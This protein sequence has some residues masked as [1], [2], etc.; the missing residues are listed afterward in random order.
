MKNGTPF[1]RKKAATV[2]IEATVGSSRKMALIT[3]VGHVS[4]GPTINIKI[5]RRFMTER[6]WK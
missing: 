6:I 4:T 3:S 2:L 5:V 1:P